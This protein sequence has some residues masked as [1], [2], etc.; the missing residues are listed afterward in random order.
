MTEGMFWSLVVGIAIG[1]VFGSVFYVAQ[2]RRLVVHIVSA[3]NDKKIEERAREIAAQRDG[4]A[5]S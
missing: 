3:D 4:E 2:V 1:F 5:F